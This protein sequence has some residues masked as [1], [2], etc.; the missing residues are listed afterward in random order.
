MLLTVS[1]FFEWI[2]IRTLA[3][4]SESFSKLSEPDVIPEQWHKI[5][6]HIGNTIN[7]NNYL[8]IYLQTLVIKYLHVDTQSKYG[9]RH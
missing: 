3:F 5:G 7:L 2:W 8:T 6:K 4:K 9:D 1:I